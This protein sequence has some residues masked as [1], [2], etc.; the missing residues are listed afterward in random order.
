RDQTLV[1]NAELVAFLPVRAGKVKHSPHERPG[2]VGTF[3]NLRIVSFVDKR[4]PLL[5]VPIVRRASGP[6]AELLLMLFYAGAGAI[7]TDDD[8]AGTIG[9]VLLVDDG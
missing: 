3:P 1:V 4:L 2:H 9:C 6:V 7:L 5:R 8:A